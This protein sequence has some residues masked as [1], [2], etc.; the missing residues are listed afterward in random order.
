DLGVRLSAPTFTSGNDR[1]EL[2]APLTDALSQTQLSGTF[3]RARDEVA[4]ICESDRGLYYS[5]TL[6][7][8]SVIEFDRSISIGL[9][10]SECSNIACRS[11]NC[12]G[13]LD[14]GTH[15][16][17]VP[18]P[19]FDR[20]FDYNLTL[21]NPLPG[22]IPPN[23]ACA[24]AGAL[25]TN[26]VN[27]A[28]VS[29]TVL[30]ASDSVSSTCASNADDV[31]Y[32]FSLSERS[33]VRITTI[34]DD[35]RHISLF[36]NEC[37]EELACETFRELQ[38]FGL[39]AGDYSVAVERESSSDDPCTPVTDY[40]FELSV[41][42]SPSPSPPANDSC[43]SPDTIQVPNDLPATVMVAGTTV[44]ADNTLSAWECTSGSTNGGEG[45]DVFYRFDLTEPTRVTLSLDGLNDG[46]L[47]LTS[48]CSNRAEICARDVIAPGFPL[49]AGRYVIAVDQGSPP[50]RA[51]PSSFTL[52][53]T[54]SRP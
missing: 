32:R 19:E 16:L 27:H 1:C 41:A 26:G 42:I 45:N 49:P 7:R 53:V 9:A 39:A 36:K 31:F 34:S 20:M 43:A 44:S 23:D 33:D 50:S 6:E 28:S 11:G 12:L 37:A 17:R 13:P 5:L 46:G 4:E 48:S 3:V 35:V 51:A 10:D 40:S 24:D 47:Y 22:S 8:P 14:P 2:A 38:A 25:N 15:I 29:G 21:R 52:S 18:D 54:F 30:N